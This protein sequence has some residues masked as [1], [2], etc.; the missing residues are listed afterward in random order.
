MVEE[1]LGLG[2]DTIEISHGL[3]VSLLP[4][5][6]KMFHAGRVKVSGLHNY[7]P[8]PVELM[9]D[10]PDAYEFTSHRPMERERAMTL[11]LRSLEYAAQFRAKYLVLHMGSVPIKHYTDELEGLIADGE[12]NSRRY[13]AKKLEFV[14]KREKTAPLY[15]QRA[16]SALET[17][18]AKAAEVGVPVAIE[19]RSHYEQMPSER[20]MVTLMD[21]FKDNPWVGYWHDFGHVQRKANLGLLDHATWLRTICH[22]CIGAHVHDVEWPKRDHRVPFMAGG[23]DLKN[24]IPLIPAGRPLVWE[25][26]SHRRKETILEGYARWKEVF[27][28]QA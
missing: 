28:P 15:Y 7:C 5:I 26:S 11:T 2:F 27:G 4:G 22:R 17:I 3:K 16:I 24:L 10:A 20:E 1:I 23:V 19:S 21:H 6:Q 12:L 18:A 8:S 25:L 13:V 14:Q 9:I